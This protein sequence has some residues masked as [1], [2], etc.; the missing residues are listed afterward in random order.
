MILSFLFRVTD[1]EPD[2]YKRDK[3]TSPSSESKMTRGGGSLE[4]DPMGMVPGIGNN[5]SIAS[6]R[7][8]IQGSNAPSSL[9]KR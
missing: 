8:S 6:K 7:I 4:V 3:S 1:R 9:Y 5:L 2:G